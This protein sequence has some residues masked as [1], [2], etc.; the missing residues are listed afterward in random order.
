VNVFPVQM[1]GQTLVCLQDPQ[2]VSESAL[3]LTPPVYFIVSLFDGQH[4]ILDIQAA[5]M[6]KFGQFLYTEKIQEVIEQLQENLFLEGDR[7][8]EALR[9]AEERFKAAPV[10]EAG[11]A[12]KSY[13]NDPER[14]RAQIESYFALPDGPGPIGEKKEA[15]G[16]KGVVAPHI[17]FQRGGACYAFAHR[18]IW[19]RNSSDCFIIFGTAHTFTENP[20]CLTRKEFLTPLGPLPVDQELVDA[21]QSRCQHDLF[22]DEGIHRSEHSIEFQCI[23]LRYLYPDPIPL[24]IVPVLCGSFHEI[25]EKGIFPLECPPIEQFIEALRESV[26]SL[27]RKVFYIASADLAHMG[28]QFGDPEGIREY[29]LRIL[30]EEDQAMLGHVERFDG[31]GFFSSISKERDRRRICGLPTIYTLIKTMQAREGRLLKYGQAFTPDTQSVVTF[32]GLAF[33]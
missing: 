17:D 24:K 16:L 1:S 8:Q 3:F 30:A 6:R 4:S 19:E 21:I 23:F 27:G 22:K 15:D 2:N 7:F 31:E 33:Y 28:L 26:S 25:I 32:A 20:F 12:G 5:Y 29:D 14:L 11:F 18:E 13:E 9:Q 10:R